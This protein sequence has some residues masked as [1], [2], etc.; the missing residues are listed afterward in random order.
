ML[1]YTIL[2]LFILCLLSSAIFSYSILL[3]LTLSLLLFIAYC[4]LRNFSFKQIAMM[5]KEGFDSGKSIFIIMLLIGM[6]TGIWRSCG[7]IPYIIYHCAHM[8]SPSYFLVGIFLFNALISFLIGSSFGTAST[9]GIISMSLALA[10]GMEPAYAGGAIL[11]GAFLGD[12]CSPMSTSALLISTLTGSPLWVNLKNMFR[13]AAV[14]FV[15]TLIIFQW[16]N[17]STGAKLDSHAVGSLSSLFSFHPLLLLPA[18]IILL[19]SLAKIPVKISMS[20]SI[21]CA[22]LLAF[23]LQQR[24]PGEILSQLIFGYSAPQKDLAKLLNGGGMISMWKTCAIIAISSSFFGI[25]QN[26]P[27][28]VGVK[29]IASKLYR[30]FPNLLVMNFMSLLIA[31]FSSNQTLC[32]MLTAEMSKE[33]MKNAEELAFDLENSAVYT[34]CFI[35]WNIAGRTPLETIGAPMYSLS[36]AV[37]LYVI[38]IYHLFLDIFHFFH[39]NS[40]KDSTSL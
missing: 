7:T 20:L 4:L 25:F 39:S 2:I 9:S 15:A 24:S 36:F 31:T 21:L 12:R 30:R 26:T 18:A 32:I 6:I 11:S 33:E 19:L 40:K 35:P 38:L 29:K 34:P 5:L 27:L 14:P 8:I 10:L 17:T 23:F 3:A 37:Y 1:E 28:L 22:L 16:L 13:T